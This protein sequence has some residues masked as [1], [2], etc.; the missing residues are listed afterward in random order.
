MKELPRAVVN[1]KDD[2]RFVAP[3][4]SLSRHRVPEHQKARA[5]AGIVLNTGR[6]NLQPI[7]FRGARCGNRRHLRIFGGLKRGFRITCSRNGFNARQVRAEPRAAL[8][9]SLRVRRDHFNVLFFPCEIHE[10]VRNRN[11]HF[12]DNG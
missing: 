10:V 1:R 12:P 5:V 3:G 7:E 6:N 8:R 4:N 9:Q 11:V 2:T